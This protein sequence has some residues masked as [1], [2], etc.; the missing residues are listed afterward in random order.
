VIGKPRDIAP[1]CYKPLCRNGLTAE[2]LL[3]AES[4]NTPRPVP[5]PAGSAIRDA[6]ATLPQGLRFDAEWR[7]SHHARALWARAGGIRRM[8][9]PG[10]DQRSEPNHAQM[11]RSFAQ[12]TMAPGF[13]A[14]QRGKAPTKGPIFGGESL[15]RKVI[16]LGETPS[17]SRAA[18]SSARL[19]PAHAFGPPRYPRYGWGLLPFASEN[20]L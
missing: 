10:H 17:E 14:P 16:G 12:P 8:C 1:N 2:R 6:I 19:D 11:R 20:G 15:R 5:C 9:S 7:F 13:Q 4:I 3:Q 18:T